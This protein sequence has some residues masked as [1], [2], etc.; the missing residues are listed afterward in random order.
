MRVTENPSHQ[1]PAPGPEASS[2][3]GAL[4]RG[5]AKPKALASAR[6]D[7][8]Q[9]SLTQTSP[10]SH[11]NSIDLNKESMPTPNNNLREPS[12]RG[13]ATDSSRSAAVEPLRGELD[14]LHGSLRTGITLA[15]RV[16]NNMPDEQAK[17]PLQYVALTVSAQ[18]KSPK[19]DSIVTL[20]EEL[21]HFFSTNSLGSFVEGHREKSSS[22]LSTEALSKG[23]LQDLGRLQKQVNAKLDQLFKVEQTLDSLPKGLQTALTQ[24]RSSGP[25]DPHFYTLLKASKTS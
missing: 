5:I 11:M 25:R 8:P 21:Q 6:L 14:L 16:L 22:G 15:L 1:T 13:L 20:H 9:A 10:S 2:Q 23:I 3:T 17:E 19:A 18:S 12:C 4:Q 24:T 7:G